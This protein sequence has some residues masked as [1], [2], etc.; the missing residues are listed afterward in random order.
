MA[1]N[2]SGNKVNEP[3]PMP[4]PWD[5]KVVVSTSTEILFGGENPDTGMT[6]RFVL[7][8]RCTCGGYE[9]QYP[10]ATDL[11]DIAHGA[12]P[13]MN[14]HPAEPVSIAQLG[15]GD[16]AIVMAVPGASAD[17]ESAPAHMTITVPAAVWDDPAALAE[18]IGPIGSRMHFDTRHN[19]IPDGFRLIGEVALPL[20]IDDMFR[21]MEL[22][23]L[24]DTVPA[25]GS[26]TGFLNSESGHFTQPDSSIHGV[27]QSIIDKLRAVGILPPE[28]FVSSADSDA[29][30]SDTALDN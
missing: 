21:Q 10:T 18:H 26:L 19:Q 29:K 28:Q 13:H 30:G 25:P 20:R 3:I 11:V 1:S 17:P 27:H 23:D 2:D 4:R 16:V 7:V 9:D 14:A 24:S 15:N 5:H 8:A 12:A 6:G 22:I